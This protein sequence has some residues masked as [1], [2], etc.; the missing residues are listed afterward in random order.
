[1][2]LFDGVQNALGHDLALLVFLS[3]QHAGDAHALATCAG[4]HAAAHGERG[5]ECRGRPVHGD[6]AYPQGLHDHAEEQD[7]LVRVDVHPCLSGS[8][9]AA[10]SRGAATSGPVWAVVWAKRWRREE[11]R[12]GLGTHCQKTARLVARRHSEDVQET[13]DRFLRRRVL[14]DESGVVSGSSLQKCERVHER[15]RFANNQDVRAQ[16]GHAASRGVSSCCRACA[17]QTQGDGS[18]KP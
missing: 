11:E 5:C 17:A 10:L 7:S 2:L 12:G 3:A 13:R 15:G 8:I 6:D 1:M 14:P 16:Q 9:E 18:A 4:R